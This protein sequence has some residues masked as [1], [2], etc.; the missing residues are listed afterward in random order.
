VVVSPARKL[1]I[2]SAGPTLEAELHLPEG[3]PPFAGVVI[4]HPHPQMG[5]DMHNMVVGTLVR[6]V[7]EAGAAA[8]RFNFRG[9]G[10]SE[11][12][13]DS[14]V[15]EQ[16]DVRAALDGLRAQ[17]EID[18]DRVAL[19]GYSFG[20]IMAL[21]VATDRD[22]LRAVISVSTPTER[23][24]KVAI[25]MLAPALF[26]LGDHDPYCEADLLREYKDQIGDDVT[27]EVVAGVD[28]FW[29][30]SDDRLVAIVQAFLKRTLLS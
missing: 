16:D 29:A 26:V 2:E 13:Y 23:G 3:E 27:I 24:D 6:A 7:T 11:G 28:H 20:A 5:G 1:R 19:S 9:V 18:G 22:D 10:A 4:C 14:G 30:G 8:L 21:A 25:H 17:P 15:G 12:K